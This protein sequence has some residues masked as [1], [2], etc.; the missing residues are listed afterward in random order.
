[1]GESA[2]FFGKI[3]RRNDLPER[4]RG[5]LP[6]N[7][8]KFLE[9]FGARTVS[10]LCDPLMMGEGGGY[11]HRGHPWGRGWGRCPGGAVAVPMGE[12]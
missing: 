4:R 10:W 1:M 9:K 5:G 6:G 11:L 7:G 3:F 12:G 2:I 8:R